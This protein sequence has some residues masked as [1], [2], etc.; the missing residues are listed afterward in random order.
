MVIPNYETNFAEIVDELNETHKFYMLTKIGLDE[1]LNE[2][3]IDT[4]I[5]NGELLI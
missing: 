1:L 4:F 2:K 3:F 5:K